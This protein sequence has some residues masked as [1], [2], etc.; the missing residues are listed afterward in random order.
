MTDY[1]IAGIVYLTKQ[2]QM[3]DDSNRDVSTGIE[4]TPEMVEA[5]SVALLMSG[6]SSDYEDVSSAQA[7]RAVLEA[8]LLQ[9]KEPSRGIPRW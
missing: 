3:S 4:I 6:Y 5:G 2:G 8:A 9:A 7:S 1:M